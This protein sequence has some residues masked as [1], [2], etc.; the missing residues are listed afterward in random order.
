MA[1]LLWICLAGALGT[2]VRYLI[3]VWATER[4]GSQ[5]PYGTLI[6]NVV[7]CFAMG[8]IAALTV[9]ALV[10]PATVR[11][12]LTTGFIGGLTTYSSFN[13]EATQLL[14]HGSSRRGGLVYVLVTLIACA[15]A[16]V[17]GAALGRRCA[18]A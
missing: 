6:V 1:R 7:G 9:H 4:L 8:L 2:G 10:L 14:L 18:E 11:L 5:L 15:A 17:L 13:Q 16:G 3:G 12:A